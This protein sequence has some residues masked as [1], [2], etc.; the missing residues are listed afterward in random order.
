MKRHRAME[1]KKSRQIIDEDGLFLF[2][3]SF[4]NTEDEPQVKFY[5]KQNDNKVKY[6]GADINGVEI[7]TEVFVK[8]ENGQFYLISKQSFI[9]DALKIYEKK[10]PVKYSD[11]LQCI[12]YE[13]E[14]EYKDNI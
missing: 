11:L 6:V 12:T 4:I 2:S 1:G 14:I 13:D 10:V 7:N 5:Y 3:L 8:R 9:D